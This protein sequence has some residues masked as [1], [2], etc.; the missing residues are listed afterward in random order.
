MKPHE[1]HIAFR[2]SLYVAC[3]MCDVILG[4]VACND[5]MLSINTHL[6]EVGHSSIVLVKI[7]RVK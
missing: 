3:D 5:V 6:G 4:F 1:G 2:N 7:K